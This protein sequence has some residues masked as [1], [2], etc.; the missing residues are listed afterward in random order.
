M[1]L[2]ASATALTPILL[3][4]HQYWNFE[5]YNETEDLSGHYFE[6]KSSKIIATDGNLIPNGKL[7][8]IKGTL[9]DFNKAK[10][11][12]E[13][14][15]KTTSGEYCGTG[16]LNLRRSVMMATDVWSIDCVGFD[17]AWIYDKQHSASTPVLSLYSKNS[18][19]KYVTL[20][21]TLRIP[22]LIHP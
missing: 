21:A 13:A 15:N 7:T 2:S 3:S 19:I 8:D 14:I 4:A 17:N 22:R 20:C 12:G 11:M 1:T 10:S 5:A 18:G 6:I 16:A 9:A